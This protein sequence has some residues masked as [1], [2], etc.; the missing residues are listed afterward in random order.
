MQKIKRG[1]I[2]VSMRLFR[3]KCPKIRMD[4]A[5]RPANERHRATEN[6]EDTEKE[7]DF[8]CALYDSVAKPYRSIDAPF[9]P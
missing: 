7:P 8:L 9:Q 4:S 3:K 5:V 2:A 1:L 6:A